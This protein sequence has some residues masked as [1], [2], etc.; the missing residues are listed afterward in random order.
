MQCT[1]AACLENGLGWRWGYRIMA[2]LYALAVI[3]TAIFFRPPPTRFRQQATLLQL[4]KSIDFIGIFLLAL[5]SAL[6]TVGLVWGGKIYAWNSSHVIAFLIVSPLVLSGF[7]I[8]G[9]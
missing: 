5:G 7:G 8:Y 4:L 1:V 9:K 2:C 6:L 3:L